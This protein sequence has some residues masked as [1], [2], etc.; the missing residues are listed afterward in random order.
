MRLAPPA[1]WSMS[2]W[3]DPQVAEFK[4]ARLMSKFG[5]QGMAAIKARS[6][7]APRIFSI[8]RLQEQ[9]RRPP[10][11]PRPSL[12]ATAG[13]SR[14]SLRKEAS[15]SGP[16][17]AA[18]HRRASRPSSAE[19]RRYCVVVGSDHVR[20]TAWAFRSSPESRPNMNKDADHR[21]VSSPSE[22][23]LS[24]PEC[25]NTARAAKTS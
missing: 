20:S 11:L 5:H 16:R 15:C 22:K 17:A 19:C 2:R 24:R 25:P 23:P 18:L 7:P 10:T 13:S 9:S 6:R 12:N 8:N 14:G 4:I 3:S 1:G 21:Q